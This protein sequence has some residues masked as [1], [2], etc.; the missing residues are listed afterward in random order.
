MLNSILMLASGGS[1]HELPMYAAEFQFGPLV[2]TNS[3][4]VS[5][6][7]ALGLIIF[8]QWAMR[9]ASLVP[10]G[11]QNFLELVVESLLTL[12]EGVMGRG[13]A[14][15]TFWFFASVFIFI[16]SANWFGLVPGVGT[17]G[18]GAGESWFS[19][20]VVKPF[21]RGVNA[22]VNMTLAMALTFFGM[23]IIWALQSNGVGGCIR[24]IFGS[25]AD[26][27]GVLGLLMAAIFIFVGVIEV[28]SIAFRPV[29]LSCR[30]FG[31]IYGGEYMLESM[32]AINEKLSWL[33][34][35]PFYFFELLV[36]LVQALVFCL[37]TA[38]FTSTMCAHDE[39]GAK[40]HH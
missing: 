8:V 20:D 40:S 29:S 27:K 36:G 33:I 23:W 26:N 18:M 4:I 35:L 32:M 10:K 12:L 5:W 37:L 38:I 9:N 34:P 19:V 31:N 3:M 25:K 13:L 7:V 30:L 17:I 11:S 16:V 1:H 28:V 24:H 15:K 6:V 39:S 14:H 2:V 21:F 22:D